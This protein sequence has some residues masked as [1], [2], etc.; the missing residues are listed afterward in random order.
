MGTLRKLILFL[1][2]DSQ[3][4]SLSASGGQ[5]SGTPKRKIEI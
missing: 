5:H 1:P 3:I 4:F 2:Q